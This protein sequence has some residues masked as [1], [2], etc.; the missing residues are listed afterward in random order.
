MPE[1]GCRMDS[2][3]CFAHNKCNEFSCQNSWNGNDS[4]L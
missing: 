2:S 3:K 4:S 1:E